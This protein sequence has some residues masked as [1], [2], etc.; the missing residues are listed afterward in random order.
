M[1]LYS[2]MGMVPT[3]DFAV[4]RVILGEIPLEVV[5][6]NGASA[7][8]VLGVE[9][10]HDPLAAVLVERNRADLRGQ[11]EG[12]GIFAYGH[13]VVGCMSHRRAERYRCDE[14]RSQRER[15]RRFSVHRVCS[16][17][18]YAYLTPAG[19]EDEREVITGPDPF[20]GGNGWS[21]ACI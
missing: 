5:C 3:F 16:G 12:R 14:C 10:E 7:R 13:Q 20:G 1:S 11:R 6:L 19:G 4:V 15:E 9:V 18:A 21:P 2:I 8:L 17:D